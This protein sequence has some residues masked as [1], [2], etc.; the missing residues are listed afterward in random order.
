M[1]IGDAWLTVG[2]AAR[3]LGV[4][5]T[6]MRKW[7]DRGHVASFRTL[8]GHRRYL[9]SELVAFRQRLQEEEAA[10]ASGSLAKERRE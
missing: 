4:S 3:L 1:I 6:T 9:R 5:E 2:R 7:T 8:G 10:L